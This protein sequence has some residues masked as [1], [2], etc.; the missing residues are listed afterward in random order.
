MSQMMKWSSSIGYPQVVEV[1]PFLVTHLLYHSL[2]CVTALNC[3]PRDTVVISTM[4][5]LI[6]PLGP[7]SLTSAPELDFDLKNGIGVA[8]D[9][10]KTNLGGSDTILPDLRFTRNVS[11]SGVGYGQGRINTLEPPFRN[12]GRI[13]EPFS[14]AER[15][16]AA[17]TCL[18][19]HCNFN[20]ISMQASNISCMWLMPCWRSL[21]CRLLFNQTKNTRLVIPTSS[22]ERCISA[23][24]SNKKKMSHDDNNE[25]DDEN[26][27]KFYALINNIHEAHDHFIMNNT[28]STATKIVKNDA[29]DVDDRSESLKKIKRSKL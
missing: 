5:I 23:S 29:D 12:V 11:G 2:E 19:D 7:D 6:I 9:H 14:P 1:D 4:S 3:V 13:Y 28:S 16:K 8:T 24:P 25:L 18:T 21:Q 20:C 26:M 10:F 27:D 22:Q 17:E 15:F